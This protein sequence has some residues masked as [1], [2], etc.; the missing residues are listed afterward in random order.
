MAPQVDGNHV[1]IIDI[2]QKE[3]DDSMLDEIYEGLQYGEGKERTLPT[4]ILYDQ[5]GLKLFEDITYLEEYCT[6]FWSR[7]SPYWISLRVS[8]LVME[9][10]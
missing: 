4:V 7:L 9:A 8:R 3:G 5:K 6:H 10:A 2:R 1:P